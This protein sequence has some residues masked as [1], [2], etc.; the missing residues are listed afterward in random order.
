RFEYVIV[1]FQVISGTFQFD[2][3]LAPPNEMFAVLKPGDWLELPCDFVI[4]G[5]VRGAEA[6]KGDLVFDGAEH[7][8]QLELTTF[9]YLNNIPT[10]DCTEDCRIAFEQR[11][12]G[13]GTLWWQSIRTQPVKFTLIEP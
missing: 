1:P 12:N 9:P 4:A 10:P 7:F 8:L 13:I 6:S 11:W 2:P 5:N 3:L